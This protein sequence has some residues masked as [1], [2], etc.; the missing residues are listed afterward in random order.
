MASNRLTYQDWIV[1]LGHDPA[2]PPDQDT[3]V[4]N[5]QTGYRVERIREQVRLAMN[6]LNESEQQ[7]VTDFY[8]L[9]ENY[10]SISRRW[11]RPVCRL[12]ALHR[13]ALRKLRAS[14]AGL[15]SREFGIRPERPPD[16]PICSSVHRAEIDRLIRSKDR[17]DTWRPLMRRLRHEFGLKIKSPQLL[18]GHHRYH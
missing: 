15:V 1:E 7:F 12:Q 8:F 18:I 14:L 6:A 16:C 5:G 17:R 3:L 10:E 13:R 4:S 9:G 2:Q 11:G